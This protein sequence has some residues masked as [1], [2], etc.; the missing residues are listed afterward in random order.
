MKTTRSFGASRSSSAFFV[1]K[2]G[3]LS[4]L[5]YPTYGFSPY[6]REKPVSGERTLP[7]TCSR[8]KSS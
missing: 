1:G 7:P 3:E 4:T 2:I 6:G 8:R 5:S